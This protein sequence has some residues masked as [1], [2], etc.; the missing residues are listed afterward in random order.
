[1][2]QALVGSHTMAACESL[3]L[4]RRLGLGDMSQL[5]GVLKES[6]GGSRMLNR[7]G[8]LIAEVL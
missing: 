7:C 8:A 2:N 1:M 6:W 5:L 3:L 4:G